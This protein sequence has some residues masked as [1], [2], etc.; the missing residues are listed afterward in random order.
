MPPPL[1]TIIHLDADAFFVSVE[2]A[3]RPELRGKKVAVGG[4]QRGIISS[5]SYEAR[6]AGVYTPMPTQ[7]AL[8]V[9][10]DLILLPHQGEYGKVSRQVFDLCET[11]TPLVQRNSIDEGY[12]DLGPCG[13]RT[14]PELEAAA[15]GLQERIWRE[16][17]VPVS[18]GLATNR[19][20]AQI[21]SKLRKPRGFVVVL[22]G[23]EAAFLAPL[24]LSRMPGVG[25]KTEAALKERGLVR[26][27]DVFARTDAE[28]AAIFGEDWRAFVARCRGEDDRPVETEREDAKSYSQQETFGANIGD[29]AQIERTAKGM[30]DALMPKVRLDGKRVRTLTVKVRYPDF[31]HESAGRSLPQATDL[32]APFYALVEPLLR[33]AWKRRQPLRLVSVKLSGVDDSPPQL[34]LFAEAQEKRRRLADVLDRLNTGRRGEEPKVR[35]G[36]QL[37]ER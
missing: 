26:V 35:H 18:L 33:Q 14:Q 2:L 30:I 20:V 31:G 21:A 5:A 3:L 13:Y 34:E 9:C 15:R 25:P 23:T 16:L 19:L 28:L 10:P 1:P 32:E 6:A 37:G 8:K 4:R 22:P 36:H 17:Q 24:E 12:L 27:A 7:R 11:L 29:F